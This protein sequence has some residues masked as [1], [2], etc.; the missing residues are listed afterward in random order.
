MKQAASRPRPPLPRPASGSCSTSSSQ[1]RPGL[2]RRAL[3]ATVEHQVGDVVG[4]RAADQELHRQVIDALRVFPMIGAQRQ[5]PA[6]RQHVTHR[7][8]RRLEGLARPGGARVD[9]IVEQE[10]AFEQRVGV[11]GKSDRVGTVVLWKFC[12]RDDVGCL[13]HDALHK[14]DQFF[15]RTPRLAPVARCFS[16]VSLMCS[17]RLRNA[18]TPVAVEPVMPLPRDGRGT[19]HIRTVRP[20][21]NHCRHIVGNLRVE[22]LTP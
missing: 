11:A 19:A 1:S 18:S 16:H 15:V 2:A 12:M 3:D 8:G 4:Q 21:E 9:E 5:R 14:P 6:L 17:T 13:V 20:R 7:T 22:D 10:M